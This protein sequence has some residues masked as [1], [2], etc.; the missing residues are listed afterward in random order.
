MQPASFLQYFVV[1]VMLL[2]NL[3]KGTE[4]IQ[5]VIQ[6]FMTRPFMACMNNNDMQ[7]KNCI[8]NW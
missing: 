8:I 6:L 1:H 4:H 5:V 2:R 7:E 3:K